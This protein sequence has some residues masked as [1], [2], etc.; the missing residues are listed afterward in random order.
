[1]KR[2]LVIAIVAF[3]VGCSLAF[4][5]NGKTV[6][7]NI[8]VTEFAQVMNDIDEHIGRIVENPD[9]LEVEQEFKRD[10]RESVMFAKGIVN[11]WE[12]DRIVEAAKGQY[13]RYLDALI[14]SLD[15]WSDEAESRLRVM[16]RDAN[17]TLK[18][19]LARIN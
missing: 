15:S 14:S 2:F 11:E 3:L 18:T 13:V 12:G 9:M 19:C 5:N 6:A 1:M 16:S 4:L 8:E 10:L 7:N 17:I